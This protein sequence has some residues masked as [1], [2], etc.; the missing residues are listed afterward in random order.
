MARPKTE[1]LL[2]FPLDVD[3]FA[4][5]K[6]KIVVAKYGTDGFAL[7]VYLLCTIFKERYY[8][9]VDEDF[10]YIVS[11][12]LKIDFK[13]SC[14][15]LDFL[16][17]KEMFDKRLFEEEN[18]LTSKS[19]QDRY[20]QAIKSKARKT[21]VNVDEKYWLLGENETENFINVY[22]G[23]E[24]SKKRYNSSKKNED[25]STKNDIKES[26]GKESKIN[27]S[28]VEE[29]TAD[30]KFRLPTSDGYYILKREFYDKLSS[31]YPRTDIDECLRNLRI[32]LE[33]NRERLKPSCN[34]QAY[35]N[36]WIARDTEQGKCRR[37]EGYEATYDLE[38]YENSY[39]F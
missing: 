21:A 29:S 6:I 2:Y 26:K 14:E 11:S 31:A 4:D 17:E 13:K 33:A 34:M 30:E 37:S 15:I 8:I 35:I 3:I 9:K 12:D 16:I 25:N 7:Y 27:E 39:D 24:L 32:W 36:T 22:N 1:G 10:N 19:I 28:K 20:Q 18:V 38:A 23:E 5:R